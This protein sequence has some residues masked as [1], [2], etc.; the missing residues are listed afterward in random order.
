MK[1]GRAELAA[2]GSL[3]LL[4]TRRVAAAKCNVS[5]R[6]EPSKCDQWRQQC[7]F[8]RK[9]DVLNTSM[10]ISCAYGCNNWS[11]LIEPRNAR[12]VGGPTPER[13]AIWCKNRWWLD[14]ENVLNSTPESSTIK[15]FLD[16]PIVHT[17]IQSWVRH[18]KS[19]SGFGS[20]YCVI[21]LKRIRRIDKYVENVTVGH[22]SRSHLWWLILGCRIWPIYPTKTVDCLE[23]G[24]RQW[25]TKHPNMN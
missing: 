12:K 17:L 20:N 4:P 16:R 15:L 19:A 9:S 18:S 21:W 8:Q 14:S 5:C 24:Q 3:L 7:S 23:F 25:R 2:L 13:S 22:I 10:S 11:E 6:L 1:N